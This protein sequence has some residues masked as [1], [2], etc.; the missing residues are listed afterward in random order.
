M[1]NS[2]RKQ[3]RPTKSE[4][5]RLFALANWIAQDDTQSKLGN[6]TI[7][8][9]STDIRM[10]WENVWR[11]EELCSK[12]L[13][14]TKD[15]LFNKYYKNGQ[16]AKGIEE[17]LPS[18][19]NTVHPD[20]Y[21]YCLRESKNP[22]RISYKTAK[23]KYDQ[24]LMIEAGILPKSFITFIDTEIT[25]ECEQFIGSIPR[26]N[27]LYIQYLNWRDSLTPSNEIQEAVVHSIKKSLPELEINTLYSFVEKEEP[28]QK[29]IEHILKRHKIAPLKSI[30]ISS[31]IDI[32]S[33]NDTEEQEE[34]VKL[35]PNQ[36]RYYKSLEDWASNLRNPECSK[37]IKDYL[38]RGRKLPFKQIR[39]FRFIKDPQK[40]KDFL[41]GKYEEVLKRRYE[42]DLKYR[43]KNERISK[44]QEK[45]KI[46]EMKKYL[47]E[48]GDIDFNDYDVENEMNGS[49]RN[50]YN[51]PYLLGYE[52]TWAHDEAGY[53]N[54]DIDTIFDGEPDAYWNID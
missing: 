26:L 39:V 53:S 8:Q 45:K 7:S 33:L 28:L 54:D 36:E 43:K 48:S 44:W 29:F 17:A 32:V 41:I 49:Q 47:K 5:D 34:S 50:Q 3:Y 18:L 11:R 13:E 46:I 14:E 6:Y 12:T 16:L 24:I 31:A 42:K 21:S 37:W 25:K 9:I 10:S 19:K 51:D 27:D 23:K 35:Y 20:I 40:A 52:G 1:D 2:T 4:E 22:W 15:Y 30:D 38:Q